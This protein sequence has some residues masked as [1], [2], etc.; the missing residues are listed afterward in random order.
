MANVSV[1]EA[2]SSV[3]AGSVTG[4][5]STEVLFGSSTGRI[6][7]SSSLTFNDT[8]SEFFFSK[9]SN[10]SVVSRTK[11]TNTG[12]GA[13]RVQAI[14]G[15]ASAGDPAFLCE[16]S[17]VTSWNFGVDNSD[18]DSFKFS[19]DSGGDVG[20]STKLTLDTSG[21]LTAAGTVYANGNSVYAG[22]TGQGFV[23]AQIHSAGVNNQTVDVR[24]T[25]SDGAAA[26]GL[27]FCNTNTLSTS[28]A[29]ICS[30]Y[31]DD[32]STEKAYVTKDGVLGFASTAI[33]ANNAQTVTVSNVGPGGA[34]VSIQEWLQIKNAA[35][36]T[37]YLPLF[38]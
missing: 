28:G 27:R 8:N 5:T 25:V 30:F 15:G 13:A 3:P 38:G 20:A 37:R 34:G 35:G 36:T 22:S 31:N 9:S 4:L 16:V 23:Y 32:R 26:I 29:K 21:N 18:S 11:N 2:D 10:G 7:S 17:G 1:W 24:G 6:T 12:A 33:S 19:T 14:V